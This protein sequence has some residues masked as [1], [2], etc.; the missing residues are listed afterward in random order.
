MCII[1]AKKKGI[2]LPSDTVIE[3]C[4]EN[5]NDGAGIMFKRAKDRKVGIVKGLMTLPDL[6]A[7]LKEMD[8]KP[9]D[10]VVYHFRLATHGGKSQ[11]NTHPFPVTE[12]VKAMKSLTGIVDIAMVHN[13]IIPIKPSQ[14]DISD[15]M[16]FIRS[17]V[18]QWKKTGSI[19]RP[20]NMKV[21][22]NDTGNSKYA[23]LDVSGNVTLVGKGWINDQGLLYSND[24]YL[25]QIG[26]YCVSYG[27]GHYDWMDEF[28][29]SGT[30]QQGNWKEWKGKTKE[31]GTEQEKE[32][33][34]IKIG[35]AYYENE[36]T[37][38]LS[39]E[40][41]YQKMELTGKINDIYE[42]LESHGE[43]L[44]EEERINLTAEMEYYEMELDILC[45]KSW[46]E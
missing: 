40:E 36:Y 17:Y 37:G 9:D 6:Q 14:T 39:E 26:R 44:P 32:Q 30:G 4:F 18:S 11:G 15:T 46:V 19:F 41:Y 24:G 38:Y 22:K 42:L 33:G 16:E 45:K 2:Q 31:Q 13:G 20:E 7:L 35:K 43:I 12:S 34:I 8:F 29:F 21:L 28:N 27:S 23:F 25:Y 1:I 3:T 5:N 10:S